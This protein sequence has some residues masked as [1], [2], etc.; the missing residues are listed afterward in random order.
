MLPVQELEKLL[1]AQS[2]LEA[3]FVEAV[4]TANSI[5]AQVLSRDLSTT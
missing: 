3:L 5:C 2:R 4:L 1:L